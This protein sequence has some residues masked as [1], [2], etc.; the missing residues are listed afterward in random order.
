MLEDVLEQVTAPNGSPS[1]R[2]TE[3]ASEHV[4]AQYLADQLEIESAMK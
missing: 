3:V 1:V 2:E 4:S